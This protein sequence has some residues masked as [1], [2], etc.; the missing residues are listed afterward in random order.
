MTLISLLPIPSDSAP[1]LTTIKPRK[2]KD[3]ERHADTLDPEL[4]LDFLTDRLQIW[5]LMKDVNGLGTIGA[6]TAGAIDAVEKERDEVQEWWEDVIELLFVLACSYP[7]L[8]PDIP[9]GDGNLLLVDM[10]TICRFHYYS[11][12]ELNYSPLP[13]PPHLFPPGWYPNLLPS[14]AEVGLSCH[15]TSQHGGKKTWRRRNRER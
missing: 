3:P 1:N 4:L 14:R 11:I 13:L 9:C 10:R 8:G 7:S 2:K 12:I 6:G 15:W 5:R